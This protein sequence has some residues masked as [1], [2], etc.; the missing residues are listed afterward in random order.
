MSKT[1]SGLI[2]I[3]VGVAMHFGGLTMAALPWRPASTLSGL[4]LFASL[5]VGLFGLF[6]LFVGFVSPEKPAKPIASV[7]PAGTVW[8]PAPAVPR[9][10]EKEN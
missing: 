7:P 1:M 4:M 6:R 9:C 8:P 10:E 3:A 5:V 2:L